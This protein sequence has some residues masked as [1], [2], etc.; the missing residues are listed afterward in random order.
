VKLALLV[1]LAV[2]CSGGGSKKPPC[3]ERP[4]CVVALGDVEIGIESFRFVYN[5]LRE[6]MPGSARMRGALDA[7]VLRAF[8]LEQAARDGIE[9]SKADAEELIKGGHLVIGGHPIPG[10]AIYY[11]D[12]EMDM[13][14]L[15]NWVHSM[16]LAGID[17]LVAEQ[18]S[19]HAAARVAKGLEAAGG[20][21]RWFEDRCTAAL[22]DG[23]L[24]LKNELLEETDDSGK[25]VATPPYRCD[26]LKE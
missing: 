9:V 10:H 17:D 21:A 16:D 26:W 20:G 22:A 13:R 4:R 18:R 25:V 6:T 15:Q 19:E 12:G 11:V 8:L 14:Q 3:A 23:R 1:A 24:T 2:G 7:L 5:G